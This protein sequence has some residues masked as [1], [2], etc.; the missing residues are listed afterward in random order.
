[1][2]LRVTGADDIAQGLDNVVRQV[3]TLDPQEVGALILQAARARTPVLT[4]RLRASGR[5]DGMHVAFTAPYSAP[6]HWG[7]KARNI[8]PNP[9]LVKGTEAAADAWLQ[10]FTDV[11]QDELNRKVR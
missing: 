3:P 8:S 9:Y 4:G 11:L 2:D 10:A 6:I 1:M 7:W 5:A